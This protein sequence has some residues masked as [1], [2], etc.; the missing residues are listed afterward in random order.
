MSG[1]NI[2]FWNDFRHPAV[3]PKEDEMKTI[4]ITLIVLTFSFA[5]AFSESVS[6]ENLLQNIQAD[7]PLIEQE[8][9][10]PKIESKRR[11]GF[12]TAQS[13]YLSG[14]P[15]YFHSK[16]I[17]TSPFSP[18]T[19]DR[20][21]QQ[22]SLRRNL[23]ST[24]GSIELGWSSLLTKQTISDITVPSQNGSFTIPSGVSTLYE[25]SVSASYTQPLMRNF[26]GR[27][28][29]LNYNSAEF[30]VSVA[31]LQSRENQEKFLFEVGSKYLEWVH[32]EERAKIAAE[33]LRLAEEILTLTR[34]KRQ[35]NLVDQVDVLRS[36][37][38]VLSARQALVLLQAQIKAVKAE[39]AVLAN[40]DYIRQSSPDYDLFDTADLPAINRAGDIIK[41]NSR[42]LKILETRKEQLI[43]LR[44]SYS[45]TGRASLDLNLGVTLKGG[46]ETFG[47]SLEIIKPDFSVGLMFSQQ[48]GSR[49]A[50]YDVART[51]LQIQQ[52]QAQADKA[53]LD[54]E[55]ALQ[56][57]L[58]QMDELVDV[59]ELNRQEIESAQRKTEEELRLYEQGRSDLTIVIQSRDNQQN[60]R[61]ILAQNAASYHRLL[62]KYRELTD[63]LL[64]IREQ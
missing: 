5:G 19:I 38:A 52:L 54:L 43:Y 30:D 11:E 62:L 27:L 53:R 57:L 40:A 17:V 8:S 3:L 35:A 31:K 47:N 61:Q 42:I 24:G 33:R 22:A 50:D 26:K 55:S 20:I 59:M 18:T 10:S 37:D 64:D 46:E 1:I 60:A 14:G 28:D 51:E 15:S 21:Q 58:I 23:W 6:L 2:Y 12:L 13:W 34:E 29:S 36:E 9:L 39:L 4:L 45:E 56:N 44:G 41:E 7:H 49:G 32:L 63:Q 16:P 48:L 25:H